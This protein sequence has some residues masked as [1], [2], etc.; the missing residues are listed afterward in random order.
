MNALIYYYVLYYRS[1]RFYIFFNMYYF[2]AFLTKSYMKQYINCQ[3]SILYK[4][5]YWVNN[6]IDVWQKAIIFPPLKRED[7]KSGI[8]MRSTWQ[9]S[10]TSYLESLHG[11]PLATMVDLLWENTQVS[12][13]F[14]TP[15][16]A[17]QN[18]KHTSAFL[19]DFRA[20]PTPPSFSASKNILL[21]V[22][23]IR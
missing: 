5:L 14:I 12:Y 18:I 23:Y 22:P 20:K 3:Y 1:Y 21:Q 13:H 7:H 10:F 8:I 9:T 19:V 15:W 11:N 17:L 2:S 6:L 16:A 4:T